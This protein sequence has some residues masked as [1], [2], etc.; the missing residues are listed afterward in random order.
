MQPQAANPQDTEG[1]VLQQRRPPSQRPHSALTSLHSELGLDLEVQSHA[2][3]EESDRGKPEL[4]SLRLVGLEI[5]SFSR[6]HQYMICTGILF[7]FTLLYGYLQELVSIHLFNRQFSLFVT[8]LQFCGYTFF[9]F[10]QWVGRDSKSNTVPIVYGITLAILQA[11]M[12]GLSN[13]SMRYLNYP[14][15]V[16][17]KSSRVI[18][19]MMFGVAFYHKRY[20]LKEYATIG[21]LVTGLLIFML[22][23]ASSSPEFDPVGVILITGSLVV[24]AGIIN[25]Q[26]YMFT[27][28]NSNEEEMIFMSYAGGSLVL[29]L[30][31]MGTGEVN[32]GLAFFHHQADPLKTLVIIVVFAACGFCGVSSVAALTKRFGA[33]IAAI[34]TT[35]RKALT[36]VLSFFFFP[37]PFL[38]GHVLG[39]VL[40]IAGLVLKSRTHSRQP[41]N[42]PAK[43]GY[44]PVRNPDK[45]SNSSA[46]SGVDIDTSIAAIRVLSE[47]DLEDGG[48]DGNHQEEE[49]E[50][51]EHRECDP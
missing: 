7:F 41:H 17:F 49:E 2:S 45:H 11:S 47:Y 6:T 27:Q 31:C 35:A 10:L 12:Q 43:A 42:D 5:G 16:L 48:Q 34:T 32:E 37:K 24:D 26:E 13:L 36:L 33:L 3:D 30:V 1:L 38:P 21:V 29:L 20:S 4:E 18:P 51:E 44:K 50:E 22:A 8:L 23:D 25:L 28:Y 15:K 19:T 46:P 14:A 9:A 39:L 40:F